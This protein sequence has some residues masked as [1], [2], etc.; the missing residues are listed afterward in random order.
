[1]NAVLIYNREGKSCRGCIIPARSR[2]VNTFKISSGSHSYWLVLL[3]YVQ[4]NIT[5]LIEVRFGCWYRNLLYFIFW[6]IFSLPM[7]AL[8]LCLCFDRWLSA[9][10]FFVQSVLLISS[11]CSIILS[12]SLCEIFDTSR[13][14]ISKFRWLKEIF[15]N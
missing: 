3:P 5:Q 10:G 7:S 8:K 9:G 1:M 4:F 6:V 2:Y 13:F 15:E 14:N 12:L 11:S